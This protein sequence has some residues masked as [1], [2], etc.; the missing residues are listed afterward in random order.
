M[1]SDPLDFI[2]KDSCL[3]VSPYA[4]VQ[5]VLACYVARR[6]ALEKGS[7]TV[8][9]PRRLVHPDLAS[10]AWGDV[11]DRVVYARSLEEALAGPMPRVA[12]EP[13]VECVEELLP[14]IATS[15]EV[16]RL[17][18]FFRRTVRVKRISG[19]L[20]LLTDGLREVRAEI[21]P[22]GVTAPRE[23]EGLEGEAL[24]VLREAFREYGA[25]TMKDA[26]LI[27]AG[28]LGLKKGEARMVLLDLARSGLVTIRDG[29]V[30]L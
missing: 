4:W 22:N 25:L 20:F 5:A 18:R 21:T 24:Q 29:Y 16:G 17:R 3:I 23:P 1:A 11:E 8:Y 7:C 12:L 10:R 9:D 2:L 30:T 6:L 14:R 19:S 13:D 26:V 28:K 27:I 15:H